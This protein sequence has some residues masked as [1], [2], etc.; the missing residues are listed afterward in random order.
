MPRSSYDFHLNRRNQNS[1][2]RHNDYI[3]KKTRLILINLMIHNRMAN[4][5]HLFITN[6]ATN[7]SINKSTAAAVLREILMMTCR[8]SWTPKAWSSSATTRVRSPE[9]RQRRY[10]TTAFTAIRTEPVPLK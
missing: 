7:R 2:N 6:G 5:N 10:I 3:K 1:W 8:L 9:C 4:F